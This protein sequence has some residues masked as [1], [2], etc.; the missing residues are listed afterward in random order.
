[1]A[2]RRSVAPAQSSRYSR[3]TALTEV[4]C[5][6]ARILPRL[7]RAASTV[8]VRFANWRPRVTRDQCSTG[9]SSCPILA[10]SLRCPTWTTCPTSVPRVGGAL[11][12]ERCH[13]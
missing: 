3:S 11:R 4:P 13:P 2:A 10:F 5:S 12:A 8:I 7:R 9:S 1:M 6:A